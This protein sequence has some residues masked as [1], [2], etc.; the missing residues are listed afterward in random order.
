MTI[1]MYGER[2]GDH[3]HCRIFM[4]EDGTR[5]HVGTLIMRIGEWQI[6]GAALGTAAKAFGPDHLTVICGDPLEVKP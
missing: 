3:V 5:A 1:A 2:R 4:G 6:F